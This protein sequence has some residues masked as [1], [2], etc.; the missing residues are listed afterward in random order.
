MKD[1]KKSQIKYQTGFR[2]HSPVTKIISPLNQNQF[3]FSFPLES[4]II[5][6]LHSSFIHFFLSLAY[7]LWKLKNHI[8]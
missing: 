5:Y 2:T 7:S 8:L 1:N 6:P 4:G 3:N